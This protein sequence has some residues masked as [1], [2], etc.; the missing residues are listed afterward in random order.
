MAPNEKN[1]GLGKLPIRIA[2]AV[3]F[4]RP[5]VASPFIDHVSYVICC[6]TNEEVVR[7][8]TAPDIAPMAHESAF[9]N[10]SAKL[11]GHD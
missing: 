7:I 1:V 5:R 4:A 11:F 8:Y 2:F 9:R 10:F 3:I 6:R